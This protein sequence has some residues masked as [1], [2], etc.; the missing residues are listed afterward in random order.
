MRWVLPNDEVELLFVDE[1]PA[2]VQVPSAVDMAVTETQPGLKGD[3]ASGGGT[4]PAKLESGVRDRGAAVRRRG[5]QGPGRHP[6]RRVRLARVGAARASLRPAPRRRL[7]ALPARGDRA[8]RST[9]C[10]TRRSRSAGSWPRP[11]SERADRARRG[12][13]RLARAGGT[14]IGSLRSSAT[15]CGSPCTRC[16]SAT[17]SRSRWRSTRP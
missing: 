1:R 3:T 6:H 5:R 10:S 4:K 11:S 8:A 13:R 2:G 7:R 16:A 9:S 12:D 15:S 17:R 14:W